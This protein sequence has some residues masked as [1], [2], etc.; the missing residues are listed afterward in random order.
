[1]EVF[2]FHFFVLLYLT[3]VGN[4]SLWMQENGLQVFNIVFFQFAIKGSLTNTQIE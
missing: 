1:M 3:A 4:T 2:S